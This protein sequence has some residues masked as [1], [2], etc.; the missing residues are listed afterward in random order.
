MALAEYVNSGLEY[1]KKLWNEFDIKKL[2]ESIGGSSAEAVEAAIYF[3]LS[4]GAG[5]CIKKYFKIIFICLVFSFITIKVLEY[6]HFL[7][8]DW[9]ALK[10]LVGI[11]GTDDFNVIINRCFDWIKEHLLLFISIVIG[12]LVGYKLG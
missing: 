7:T 11:N 8:V 1:V 5:F 4:F 12:F 2:S 6:T 9:V 10:A 3:C